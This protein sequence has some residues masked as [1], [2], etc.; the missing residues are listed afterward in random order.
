MSIRVLD[1]LA[2]LG[3]VVPFPDGFGGSCES[4]GVCP[5]QPLPKPS[6]HGTQLVCHWNLSQNGV[7]LTEH[8]PIE[9]IEFL[10]D[11]G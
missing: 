9:F 1:T 8:L 4:V 11:T 2:A 6:E 10:S 5:T 7:W 3:M